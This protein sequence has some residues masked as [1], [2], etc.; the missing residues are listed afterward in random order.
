MKPF[1]KTL[2]YFIYNELAFFI[3]GIIC[4][5][6]LCL[7]YSFDLPS[8]SV[9]IILS[10]LCYFIALAIGKLRERKRRT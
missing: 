10:S 4:L 7:S 8:G 6:G 2:L 1:K 5:T 9:I 3:G